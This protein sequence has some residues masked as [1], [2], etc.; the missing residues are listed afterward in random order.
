MKTKQ[1]IILT[2]MA[3]CG[4]S[5]LGVLLAKTL[6][7]D[8][9]DTDLLI[10]HEEGRLLQEIIDS[11]GNESFLEIEERVLS[12][13][14]VTGSVIATGGSACYSDT[15]MNALKKSGTA[16]YISLPYSEIEK[17]VKNL[18]CRG[19]VLR[20]G[21]TLKDAFEERV[22]LYKKH[23]DITVECAGHTIEES[24]A[25][26]ISELRKNGATG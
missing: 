12:R 1:N 25:V 8:F 19:V 13:V 22:P 21:N 5:T 2:G 6:G 11:E 7:M 20:K 9:I 3:G 16:V 24:L 17:R 4:K 15:A 26:I 23:A 14:S 18:A 10:Q